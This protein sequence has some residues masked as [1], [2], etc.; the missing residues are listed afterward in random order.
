M[1]RRARQILTAANLMIFIFFEL[2][3]ISAKKVREKG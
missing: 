3:D 1:P 2:D